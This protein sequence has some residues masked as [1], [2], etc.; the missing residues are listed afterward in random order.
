MEESVTNLL[1]CVCIVLT[2]TRQAERVNQ[3]DNAGDNIIEMLCVIRDKDG[4]V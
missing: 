2:F 4:P 3:R 1:I